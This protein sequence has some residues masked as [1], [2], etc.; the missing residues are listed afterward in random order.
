MTE[1]KKTTKSAT[2]PQRHSLVSCAQAAAYADVSTKTVRRWISGGRLTGYRV[3]PRLVKVD[4]AD[5]DK[6][7]KRVPVVD[8]N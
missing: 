3:G 4:L 8:R 7:I 1:P 5:L 6:M 2:T